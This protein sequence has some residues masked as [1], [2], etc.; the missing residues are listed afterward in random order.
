[1]SI[2][3]LYLFLILKCSPHHGKKCVLLGDAAHAMVPFYGQ[4]MN[5]GFEDCVVFF[6]LLDKYGFDNL[7]QLLTKYS[8]TRVPDAHAICDLAIRNYQEMS[9][10]V[11]TKSYR[12][13]KYLDNILHVIF[14]NSWVPLYTMVGFIVCF[15]LFLLKLIFFIHKKV[16]FT[17]IKYSEVIENRKKQDKVFLHF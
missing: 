7:D 9:Y 12:L 1:M 11:T 13:R 17:R 5:C 14:P 8:E 2:N 10:L 4:G 3:I 16:T 6:E 15:R